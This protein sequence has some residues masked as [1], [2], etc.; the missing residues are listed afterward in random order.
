MGSREAAWRICHA[1]TDP[2]L[3]AKRTSE[4]RP[5]RMKWGGQQ[6]ASW[7]ARRDAGRHTGQRRSAYG[8]ARHRVGHGRFYLKPT[9]KLVA[10]GLPSTDKRTSHSPAGGGSL[11]STTV[12]AAGSVTLLRLGPCR[13]D[14]SIRRVGLM[15]A[16]RGT[17]VTHA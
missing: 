5:K 13:Y 11:N 3:R 14:P 15:S 17:M 4:K 8:W 10:P 16:M 2:D 12:V 7:V 9:T 1:R 6:A